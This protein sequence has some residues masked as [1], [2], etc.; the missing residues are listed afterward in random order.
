[1]NQLLQ[2][3]AATGGSRV[4]VVLTFLVLLATGVVSLGVA[5]FVVRGYRQTRNPAQLSLAI[6]LVL[7]TVGP[8]ASQF[9]FSNFTTV[10][11]G[12]RSLV[13]NASKLLGLGAMLYAIYGTK[14]TQSRRRPD[15][16]HTTTGADTSTDT[17]D[18]S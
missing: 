12:V 14:T 6:G 10:S 15:P 2:L 5:Y 4:V 9:L 1:M 8:I 17:E 18:D 3:Q 16:A 11:L 13:A 7:L